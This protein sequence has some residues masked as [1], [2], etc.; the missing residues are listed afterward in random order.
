MDG[1]PD[2]LALHEMVGRGN[3][4]SR[5]FSLK[6]VLLDCVCLLMEKS[7]NESWR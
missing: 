4:G 7:W 1:S 3:M 6:W 2:K 5:T